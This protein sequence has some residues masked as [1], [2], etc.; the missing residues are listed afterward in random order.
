MTRHI[1][2]CA[3]IAAFGIVMVNAQVSNAWHYPS[4]CSSYLGYGSHHGGSF[5]RHFRHRHRAYR[6]Y[7]FH[8]C[9]GYYSTEYEWMWARYGFLN[10]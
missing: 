6:P 8:G 10:L 3:I 2:L 4:E 9:H 7:E 1:K 5:G